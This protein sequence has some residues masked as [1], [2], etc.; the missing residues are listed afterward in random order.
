V[1]DGTARLDARANRNRGRD[2]DETTRRD[3]AR[4]TRASRAVE[5]SV[6]RVPLRVLRRREAARRGFRE[7]ETTSG[8]FVRLSVSDFSASCAP[9]NER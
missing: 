2:R 6:A 9:Y 5:T 7:A 8:P 1:R 4:V 3:D